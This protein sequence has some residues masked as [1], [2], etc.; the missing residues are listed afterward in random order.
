MS[1]SSYHSAKEADVEIAEARMMSQKKW[2]VVDATVRTRLNSGHMSSATED[3]MG[4]EDIDSALAK[5][6]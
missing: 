2:H 3:Y 6:S 1:K 5:L 4:H